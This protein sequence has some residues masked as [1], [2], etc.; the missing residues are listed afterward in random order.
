MHFAR[1]VH[2]HCLVNVS[3]PAYA[4]PTPLLASGGGVFI[5]IGGPEAQVTLVD[6]WFSGKPTH[7]R[8]EDE[9]VFVSLTE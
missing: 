2:P 9:V 8:G 4:R 1:V 6:S 5:D 7:F 3:R